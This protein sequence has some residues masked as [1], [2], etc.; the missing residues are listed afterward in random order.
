MKRLLFK[1][2]R[3][4]SEEHAKIFNIINE[5][6]IN[7][8]RNNNGVFLSLSTIP[9]NVLSLVDKYVDDFLQ[10]MNDRDNNIVRNPSE[11]MKE[12]QSGNN[13]N[14]EEYEEDEGDGEGREGGEEGEEGEERETR[15]GEKTKK[16][17]LDSE[18][19]TAKS[20]TD[21][22][23]NE[24]TDVLNTHKNNET[25]HRLVNH[26]EDSIDNLQKKKGNIKY[27]NAIKKY[28]RIY[29]NDKKFDPDVKNTLTFESYKELNL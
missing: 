8:T 10:K 6:D 22:K 5:H 24:W 19:N 1:I 13:D 20:I 27:A 23:V 25:I 2:S 26:L 4:S 3:L 16:S 9:H 15:E 17:N 28:G 11:N 14:E 21:S 7:F 12:T 29:T 18:V